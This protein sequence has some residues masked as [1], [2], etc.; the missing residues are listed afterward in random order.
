MND[1]WQTLD[2]SERNRLPLTRSEVL[3]RTIVGFYFFSF[4]L[5]L[6]LG[7]LLGAK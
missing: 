6:A 4:I 5:G 7:L 3:L 2:Q 1:L